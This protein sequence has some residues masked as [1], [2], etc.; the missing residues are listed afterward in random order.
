MLLGRWERLG[1]CVCG[2]AAVIG[3]AGCAGTRTEASPGARSATAS[4]VDAEVVQRRVAFS[5]QINGTDDENWPDTDELISRAYNRV[6]VLS[7]D[8]PK[9][10]VNIPDV[11]WGGECR[12][13]TE[14]SVELLGNGRVSVNAV[15]RLYE[16]GSESTDDLEDTKSV[17]FVVPKGGAPVNQEIQ[18]RNSGAGGGDHAEI[19]LT[20]T[21]S[22]VEE[23]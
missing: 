13:E 22:L 12:V 14:V 17:N 16:G 8:H 4:F 11:R 7:T 15:G 19:S 2:A 21:N 9:T 18:L 5:I 10:S 6:V 3:G 1:L 20:V 23:E